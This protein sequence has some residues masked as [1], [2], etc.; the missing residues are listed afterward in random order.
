MTDKIKLTLLG[1]G[2]PTPS[3]HRAGSSYLL[4]VGDQT[5]LE[6]G[7]IFAGNTIFGQ[8]LLEVP[9]VGFRL[10]LYADAD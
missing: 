8:D 3:H 7:Q 10:E 9:S 1:T 5:L 6:V 2:T 4:E